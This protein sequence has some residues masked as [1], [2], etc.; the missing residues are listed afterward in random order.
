MK[1]LIQIFLFLAILNSTLLN[2]QVTI[3]IPKGISIK[4]DGNLSVG[5]WEDADSVHIISM[6]N[7]IVRVLF[8]H[9]SVSL[10]FAYLDNL[11]SANF[12]FPE[13]LLD[14]N[15][16][17]SLSW[18]D[19]DWWFHVSATNCNHRGAPNIYDN[20]HDNPTDWEANNFA[21]NLPDIVEI[22]IPFYLVGIDSNTVAIG[23]AFDVTNTFSAWEYY[24]STSDSLKPSTWA[25]A[26]LE[27][28]TSVGYYKNEDK[29]IMNYPNPFSDKTYFKYKLD[30]MT[31]VKLIISNLLGSEVES[32]VNERQ[33]E[34]EYQYSFYPMNL[35]KGIYFYKFSA[36]DKIE[37]GK[38]LYG[39]D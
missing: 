8:K 36:G 11:G 15:N 29:Q 3:N 19:D 9:D 22:K 4:V 2:S 26:Y 32:I 33:E 12:R 17:K 28:E 1:M 25:T 16:D 18:M 34:G 37:T 23:I 21:V 14:I 6:N 10:M 27:K 31:N 38:L 20:C 30:G 24:P 7:K 39:I 13:L 5:E 35:N